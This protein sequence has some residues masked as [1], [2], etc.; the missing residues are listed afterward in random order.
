MTRR[1]IWTALVGLMLTDRIASAAEPGVLT[2]DL[3]KWTHVDVVH[4]G[5]LIRV[6]PADIFR[7]LKE[8]R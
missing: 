6:T 4:R 5:E 3:G 8:P 2:L 1:Q 7:A